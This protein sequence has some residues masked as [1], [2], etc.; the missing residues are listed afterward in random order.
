MAGRMET[1]KADMACNDALLFVW[2]AE[3]ITSAT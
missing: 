1:S 3:E 2:Q